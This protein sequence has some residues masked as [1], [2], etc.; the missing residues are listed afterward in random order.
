MTE[1]LDSLPVQS[2]AHEPALLQMYSQLSWMDMSYAAAATQS[3][4]SQ[5]DEQHREVISARAV[6]TS[7][8][9]PSQDETSGEVGSYFASDPLGAL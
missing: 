3:P 7:L 5:N 2:V 6:L 8:T 4:H 1:Q 9:R